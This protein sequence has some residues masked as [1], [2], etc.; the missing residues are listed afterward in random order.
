MTPEQI[1]PWTE[2]YIQ[3][4]APLALQLDEIDFEG[5]D[6][7]RCRDLQK[8]LRSVESNIPECPDSEVENLLGLALPILHS[9][10]DAC[11]GDNEERWAS[12]LLEAKKLIHKAQVLLDERYR[13]AGISEL[14]LE[15]AIGVQRSPSSISGRWLIEMEEKGVGQTFVDED[16]EGLLGQDDFGDDFGNEDLGDEDLGDEDLGDEDFE[17]EFPEDSDALDEDALDEEEG[18]GK[19]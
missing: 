5:I 16:L 1:K 7:S 17:E 6:Q 2:E 4:M 13:F 9:S 19:P 18:F 14:E 10:A 11:R 12:S 8:H 15:S 3:W